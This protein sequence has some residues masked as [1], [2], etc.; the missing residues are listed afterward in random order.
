MSEPGSEVT[1]Y[2]DDAPLTTVT[3]LADG[4]FTHVHD[5]GADGSHSAYVQAKAAGRRGAIGTP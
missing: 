3:A 1:I 5:F 2:V 4:S